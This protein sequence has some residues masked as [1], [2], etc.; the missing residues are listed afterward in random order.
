[1]GEVKNHGNNFALL[2]FIGACMVI[3]GH[4]HDLLQV[5]GPSL[6]GNGINALGV[7]MIFVITGYLVAN[8]Y[9]REKKL[10]RYMVRRLIRIYP[11]MFACLFLSVVLIGPIATTLDMGSY[12]SQCWHY[13]WN[14]L[15]L[16]PDYILPGVF[17][18]N[19]YP[20]AVNGSLWT[21]PVEVLMYLVVALLCMSLYR[22]PEKQRKRAA[23]AVVALVCLADAA[24]LYLAP[25]LRTVV[26]WT[27][28]CAALN[29]IP[30]FLFGFLFE[31]GGLKKYCN[32]QL[33]TIVFV[34]ACFLQWRYI[35]LI[36]ILVVPYFV[37]SFALCE[38][39]I[40]ANL[41]TKSNIAYGVYLWG[42]PIQQLLTDFLKVRWQMPFGPNAMFLISLV[43]VV[44]LALLSHRFL[45]IPVEGFLKRKLLPKRTAG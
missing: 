42:F 15:L 37:M 1:M 6:L 12:F 30:Y 26:W 2:H 9:L 17:A 29:D 23:C 32:L 20:G 7:K 44:I 45:E 3:Y 8:S 40:F 4:M 28:W 41:F 13:L 14:N 10:G 16:R 18:S 31:A 36:A 35:E 25:E 33:A 11:A 5:P 27:D 21:M 22:L 19:P 43:P 34:V 24:R 39:P 38:K